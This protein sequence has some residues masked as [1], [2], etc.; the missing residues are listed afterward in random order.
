M[1]KSDLKNS[2]KICFSREYIKDYRKLIS[3]Y[4]SEISN[5]GEFLNYNIKIKKQKRKNL[6]F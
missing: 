3:E 2:Q 6:N 4:F 5:F 1:K